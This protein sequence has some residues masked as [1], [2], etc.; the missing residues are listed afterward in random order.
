M[1]S[2][3]GYYYPPTGQT[4]TQPVT[5]NEILDNAVQVLEKQT[6]LNTFE[7]GVQSEIKFWEVVLKEILEPLRFLLPPQ[8]GNAIFSIDQNTLDN[9]SRYVRL[10]VLDEGFFEKHIEPCEE[11]VD[12]LPFVRTAIYRADNTVNVVVLSPTDRRYHDLHGVVQVY[13]PGEDAIND[14]PVDG[15]WMNGLHF[16]Q[17]YANDY[18][19]RKATCI[20]DDR[21]S[22]DIG[23]RPIPVEM[24]PY[25][26]ALLTI[27]GTLLSLTN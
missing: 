5:P 2:A 18:Y 23:P 6:G 17:N 12:K 9:A 15:Q 3:A 13:I 14:V 7:L 19:L 26:P 21:H 16:Y 20:P 24:Q 27:V 8:I 4:Y 10:L 25:M 22:Q 11:F 1:T